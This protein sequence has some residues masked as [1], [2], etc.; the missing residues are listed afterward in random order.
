MMS[1][2]ARQRQGAVCFIAI[3]H[4]FKPPPLPSLLRIIFSH[5]KLTTTINDSVLVVANDSLLVWRAADRLTGRTEN[6]DPSCGAPSCSCCCQHLLLSQR[7]CEHGGAE[8]FET[9]AAGIMQ[10][11]LVGIFVDVCLCLVMLFLNMHKH[12][13]FFDTFMASFCDCST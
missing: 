10:R 5:I 11:I 3:L 7:W 1:S 9:V 2:S 6:D 12:Y 13:K 4:P 8:E